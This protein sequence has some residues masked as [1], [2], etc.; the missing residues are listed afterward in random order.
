MSEQ[1]QA[2]EQDVQEFNNEMAQRR[3]KLAALREQGNAFPND[4]RRDHI[5]SDIHAAFGDKSNEELEALGAKVKIA[6]RIM[7]RRIMGKASFATLQDMG[8]RSR[9]T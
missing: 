8:G 6:G 9:F 3:S 7:T 1:N 2:P 4:F 5:S